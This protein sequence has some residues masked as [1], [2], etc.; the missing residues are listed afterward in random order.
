ERPADETE[1]RPVRSEN[2]WYAA[3][4]RMGETDGYMNDLSRAARLVQIT[5][6]PGVEPGRRDPCIGPG[7]RYAFMSASLPIFVPRMPPT[8]LAALIEKRF[9]LLAQGL[10]YAR[11]MSPGPRVV[12]LVEISSR[13]DPLERERTLGEA[14]ATARGIGD[15]WHRAHALEAL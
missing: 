1:G 4:E 12:A 10:A 13:L 2:A 6:Q 7:I 9:W 11:V 15:E 3:R 14:L 5:H 8:L